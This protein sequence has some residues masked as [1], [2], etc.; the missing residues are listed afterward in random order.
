LQ[1]RRAF[2]QAGGLHSS[3]ALHAIEKARQHK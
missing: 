2:K 3:I 1:R